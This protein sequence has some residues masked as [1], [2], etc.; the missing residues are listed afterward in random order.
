MTFGDPASHPFTAKTIVNEWKEETIA[1]IL[2]GYGEERY[3]R[4]IAKGVVASREEKPIGTTS[5]LAGIV[6]SSVP[7]LYRHGKLDPSTRTFQALRIAVN[8]E[9]GALKEGLEKGWSA[10][11]PGG[12]MAV[13]SFHSLEDRIVKEFFKGRAKEG[14][15][16]LL[17]KKPVTASEQELQGNPR[18][19][20]AKLRIIEKTQ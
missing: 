19:R 3:A 8:D 5:E 10:L 9:L 1:D 7:A 2:Y 20:S 6:R 16:R 15:G 12:R 13:I 17:N 11:R 18:A 14:Q 4:R